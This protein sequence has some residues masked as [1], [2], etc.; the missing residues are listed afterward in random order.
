MHEK[1]AQL[2]KQE[3]ISIILNSP[4]TIRPH[5]FY[6][7]EITTVEETGSD[8][9]HSEFPNDNPITYRLLIREQ[10][11]GR[12]RQ[13]SAL[14]WILQWQSDNLPTMNESNIMEGTS[15]DQHYSEFPNDNQ[16]TYPLWMREQHSGRDRHGSGSFWIPQWQSDHLPAMNESATQWKRQAEI[17][18]ILNSQMTI[19][20]L[21]IYEWESNTMEEISKDQYH[22]EFPNDNQATY[23]LWMREQHSRWDRQGSGSFWI[24]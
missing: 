16:T 15:R 22:S 5:T 10:H 6:E 1:A 14:F 21:T 7:W 2:K 3:W 18:I 9:Y 11:S 23:L 20:P 13:G 12:D 4:I 24:P 19:R 8:Q 17:R